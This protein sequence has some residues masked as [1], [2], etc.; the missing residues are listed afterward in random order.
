MKRI[1]T[2]ALT[3]SLLSA[4][5]MAGPLASASAVAPASHGTENATP[6]KTEAGIRC[7]LGLGRDGCWTPLGWPPPSWRG[8]VNCWTSETW[9]AWGNA[10]PSGPLESIEYLGTNA[11]GDDVYSAKFMHENVTYVLRSLGPDGK[12][13]RIW[14]LPQNYYRAATVTSPADPV[15][16]LYT[17]PRT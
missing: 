15:Q 2:I 4:P 17:R 13:A 9:G 12:I 8:T 6:P 7:L 10:C 11:G 14:L 3:A 16:I 1:L 5:V